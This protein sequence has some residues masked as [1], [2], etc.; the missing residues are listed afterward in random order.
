M[1]VTSLLKDPNIRAA[2]DRLKNDPAVAGV[3]PRI[4]AE[5][6]EVEESVKAM[7]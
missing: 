6:R 1:D 4:S 5:W 7:R 2:L 3:V